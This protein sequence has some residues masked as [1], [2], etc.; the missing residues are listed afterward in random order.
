MSLGFGSR[1]RIPFI[2]IPEV[3]VQLNNPFDFLY[4]AEMPVNCAFIQ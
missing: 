1:Y 3:F 2:G 4:K